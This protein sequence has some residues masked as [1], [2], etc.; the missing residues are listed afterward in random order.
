MIK[1]R[2]AHRRLPGYGGVFNV[3]PNAIMFAHDVQ[4]PN[5][6][7]NQYVRSTQM[8]L[9]YIDISDPGGTIKLRGEVRFTGNLVDWGT[10]NGRWNLDFADGKTAHLLG[11]DVNQN[12]NG[13][14]HGYVLATADF[15]NPDAPGGR[16]DAHDPGHRL[17]ARPL[18][19]TRG[20][21]T[22]RRATATTAA[23]PTAAR[24]SRSSTSSIP[25]RPSSPGTHRRSP[26]RCGTSRPSGDGTRLFALGNE[27]YDPING[28]TATRSRCGTSTSPTRRSRRC[29]APRTFGARVGVDAGGAARSRRSPRTTTDGLV[30][31]PFSGWSSESTRYNNGLQLIEFTPTSITHV[32]RRQHQ[33]LGRARHLRRKARAD[34]PTWLLSLSDLSLAVVDYS[35]HG[36]P[37]DHLRAAARAQRHRCAPAPTAPSPQLSS[38]WSGTTTRIT[39]SCAC[40]P[41]PTPR[42]TSPSRPSTKWTSKA[43][44]ARVFHNGSSR[45]S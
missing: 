6:M 39:P 37:Q 38:D 28:S 29:S 3:T 34:S 11:R 18:A 30:V 27:G 25:P 44:N 16:V 45:T 23:A 20:A 14:R 12:Q 43:S 19:S 42:R 32:G 41:S 5:T 8:A 22:S 10:D 7:P 4:P 2:R 21:C 9:D 26:A 31:L 35:V 33:G 1:C 15:T 13:A 40:S 24:R 17:A 36:T